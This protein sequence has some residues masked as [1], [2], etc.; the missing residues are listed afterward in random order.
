MTERGTIDAKVVR[1]CGLELVV[2][3]VNNLQVFEGTVS[4]K[5]GK[6]TNQIVA[7]EFETQY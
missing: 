6:G 2:A 5:V 4:G 1:Y 7:G 3:H